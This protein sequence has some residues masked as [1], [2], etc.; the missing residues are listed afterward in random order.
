MALTELS[1]LEY[2]S[3]VEGCQPRESMLAA[4]AALAAQKAIPEIGDIGGFALKAPR[5]ERMMS[6][7]VA[8]S[9]SIGCMVI[10]R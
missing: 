1:R 6:V 5:G 7:R 2:D 3:V 4:L 8:W 9:G 10:T